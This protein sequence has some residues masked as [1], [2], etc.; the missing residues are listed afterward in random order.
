[1]ALKKFFDERSERIELIKNLKEALISGSSDSVQNIKVGNQS[2]YLS[3]FLSLGNMSYKSGDADYFEYFLKAMYQV[4]Q[5]KPQ[6]INL[7]S[8]ERRLRDYAF[9]SIRAYD[10]AMFDAVVEVIVDSICSIRNVVQ[11]DESLD[12][13]HAISVR[14]TESDFEE[15]VYAIVDKYGF[16]EGHFVDQELGVS[17]MSLRNHIIVLVHYLGNASKGTLQKRVISNVNSFMGSSF[18]SDGKV[19]DSVETTRAPLKT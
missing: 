1:M 16:L 10:L 9:R 14:A 4:I 3:F 13:L 6:G 19:S 15:G 18:T 11:I 12:F 7:V 17:L 8:L 2:E 5:A